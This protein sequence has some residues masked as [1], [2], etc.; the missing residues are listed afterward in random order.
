MLQNSMPDRLKIRSATPDDE[1][2]IAAL[3]QAS[4]WSQA[5]MIRQRTFVLPVA[6]QI[7]MCLSESTRAETLL[8]ALWLGMT[9]IAVGFIMSLLTPTIA[10]MALAAA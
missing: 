1:T 4:G 6:N 10:D 3:W 2:A 8:A 7:R 5:I 9:V